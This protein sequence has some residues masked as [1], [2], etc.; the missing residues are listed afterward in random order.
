MHTTAKMVITD[1]QRGRLPYFTLPPQLEEATRALEEQKK[2]EAAL[3]KLK[4]VD[5]SQQQ[6]Q[7]ALKDDLQV[8]SVDGG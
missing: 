8:R 5:P 4:G 6:Q 2:Q 7:A 1:W 3:L